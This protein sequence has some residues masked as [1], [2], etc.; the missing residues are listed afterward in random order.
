MEHEL[1]KGSPLPED[2]RPREE[3]ICAYFANCQNPD[4]EQY[5]W[6]GSTMAGAT[7]YA[8]DFQQWSLI[9]ELVERAP[10]HIAVLQDIAAGP[11]EGFLGRFDDRVIDRV[12]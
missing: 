12:E 11:L 3:V 10:D 5:S 7:F 9:L 1:F 8:N 6:A 4:D 2:R